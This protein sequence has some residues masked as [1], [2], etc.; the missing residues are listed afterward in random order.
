MGIIICQEV[1][2]NY[3][4]LFL[5]FDNELDEINLQKLKEH[6]NLVDTETKVHVYINNERHSTFN[7][8]FTTGAT[9]EDLF[10]F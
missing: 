10:D 2:E 1:N 3:L 8:K 5:K 4:H 6:I 7:I 9:E